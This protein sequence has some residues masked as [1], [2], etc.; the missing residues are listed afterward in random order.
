MSYV[1]T[2]H[3]GTCIY[4]HEQE[5]SNNMGRK[6]KPPDK[7]LG[8]PPD[9]LP[10]SPPDKPPGAP[11]RQLRDD[12]IQSI[13][14]CRNNTATKTALNKMRKP[15]LE[16]VLEQ[17]QLQPLNES[18]QT[19]QE[20]EKS[21]AT[22]VCQKKPGAFSK[23]ELVQRILGH[24]DNT[25]KKTKLSNL[26]KLVLC[27][28]A[29]ALGL[30]G[31]KQYIASL[32]TRSE[33][34]KCYLWTLVREPRLRDIIDR[35]VRWWSQVWT[36]GTLIINGFAA[37]HG[38]DPTGLLDLTTLK[39]ALFPERYAPIDLPAGLHDWLNAP[40]R[41]QT[42]AAMLPR[43]TDG[44]LESTSLGDQ[45]LTYM[46]RRYRGNLKGH[47]LT[48]LH[49]RVFRHFLRRE[50]LQR[51]V[52]IHEPSQPV[53]HALINGVYDRLSPDDACKVARFRDWLGVAGDEVIG[54]Q[55][56]T[57]YGNSDAID[58]A[59]EVENDDD[60]AVANDVLHVAWIAHSRMCKGNCGTTLLP[61]AELRRHHAVLDARIV[62]S[63]V[64]KHNK[65][66]GMPASHRLPWVP[67]SE[68]MQRYFGVTKARMRRRKSLRRKKFAKRA[69]RQYLKS[70]AGR[71]GPK[72]GVLTTVQTDGVAASPTFDTPILRRKKVIFKMTDLEGCCDTSS[73]QAS[74]SS[75][76]C[77]MPP[78]LDG[79][80][81]P[82]LTSVE[83]AKLQLAR[84]VGVDP[85]GTNILTSVELG[86]RSRS[87]GVHVKV[88]NRRLFGRE[89][90]PAIDIKIRPYEGRHRAVIHSHL[91]LRN[92][93]RR[94]L[95]HRHQAFES[96]RRRDNPAYMTALRALGRAGSWSTTNPALL[97]DMFAAQAEAW[98]ALLKELVDKKDHVKWK[99]LTYRRR[100]MLLDQT[101]RRILNPKKDHVP[102]RRS[103]G[104]VMGYGN[105]R[106]GTRGP[107]LLMIKA[108]V[109][110]MRDL[111][112][113]GLPA[114]LVF[115]DEFRTT[116]RCH[117]CLE[118]LRQPYRK[119]ERGTYQEDRRYKDCYACGCATCHPQVYLGWSE[120]DTPR[121]RDCPLCGTEA[122]PKRWGRDSNAAL[123]ML[124]KLR[125]KLDGRELPD[126]FQRDKT[127]R[128]A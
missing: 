116:Q 92:Y 107:R 57:D 54:R 112:N 42:F 104:V 52:D 36:R 119:T 99:M 94:S 121:F 103:R 85:G 128:A 64:Q 58:D 88:T 61:L 14:A 108:V 67:E 74:T 105:A 19:P 18:D 113:R 55:Y 91:S 90:D 62:Y 45:A 95:K 11:K 114:V 82:V 35:Y 29:L 127:I 47:L 53:R 32:P 49:A 68:V 6:K 51:Y 27:E 71:L 120:D 98:P 59:G 4:Y 126:A 33:G 89:A 110:A 41:A 24:A 38:I 80:G 30:L 76:P 31:S 21:K 73:C 3:K 118:V 23:D 77:P 65:T 15:D 125:L 10:D 39:K 48:H 13:L 7:P 70:F 43:D 26:S 109:R 56:G 111:R 87:D 123:N 102:D 28:K 84:Q 50:S 22:R 93:E 34:R 69:R 8:A 25:T 16:A 60:V 86:Q 5:T 97:D 124:A 83:V 66:E 101:A 44:G 12:V 96:Q 40:H 72:D 122:A 75:S 20:P 115:V 1:I 37:S 100:R 78:L 9:K 46:A 81:V 17:L 2:M 106:F 79:R 63:M 117:R